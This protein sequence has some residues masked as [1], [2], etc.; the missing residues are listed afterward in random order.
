M[1]MEY[2]SAN[3]VNNINQLILPYLDI[4]NVPYV[5]MVVIT[6]K[7]LVDMCRRKEKNTPYNFQQAK[8]VINDRLDS[9]E[10]T[11]QE[12]I[13]AKSA[14]ELENTKNLLDE[15][16]NLFEERLENIQQT[17]DQ[18]KNPILEGRINYIEET[19]DT[20]QQTLE[21]TKNSK[22]SLDESLRELF[23]ANS[24]APLLERIDALNAENKN[25][26]AK[27]TSQRGVTTKKTNEIKK[28]QHKI[29][30]LAEELR[31]SKAS[32]DSS[33]E[34]NPSDDD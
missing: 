17:L 28:L 9:M 29:S 2:F 13:I 1:A 22:E 15:R 14:T 25:L 21:E 4:Q 11:L 30:G 16:L 26:N 19:L 10:E 27:Y 33:S 31:E 12:A 18:T 24:T 8:K 7:N 23:I 20:I 34:Y 6:V 5:F 32:K 3:F